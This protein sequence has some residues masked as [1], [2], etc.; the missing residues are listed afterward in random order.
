MDISGSRGA[1]AAYMGDSG[2]LT[3]KGDPVEL[4]SIITKCFA[5]VEVRIGSVPNIYLRTFLC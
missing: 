3:A 4:V 2:L 5:E 1:L